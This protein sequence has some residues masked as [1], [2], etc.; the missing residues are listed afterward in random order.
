MTTVFVDTSFYIAILN[1]S[2]PYRPWADRIAKSYA[3]RYVTT[4]AVLTE[5][6]NFVA[7][8]S[9]RNQFGPL[10]EAV[11][12]SP[13]VDLIHVDE[14][15]WRR[16]VELYCARPDKQW[17]LID[18]MSFLVMQDRQIAIVLTTDH[19]FEQAGFEILLKI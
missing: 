7:A 8:R 19:H 6:A 3:G 2:D 14:E 9:R 15:L 12:Q 4:T 10:C 17:S 16:A 11:V 5:T 18:C 1:P 13:E